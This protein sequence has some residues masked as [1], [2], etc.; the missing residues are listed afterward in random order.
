MRKRKCLLCEKRVSG[1]EA[2]NNGRR[3]SSA[4]PTKSSGHRESREG[5][6]DSTLSTPRLHINFLAPTRTLHFGPP[7]KVD[8]PHCISWERTQKR[9][10]HKL[11][12]ISGGFWGSKRVCQMGLS[13]PQKVEFIVFLPLKHIASGVMTSGYLQHLTYCN[14]T[15]K[16]KSWDWGEVLVHQIKKLPHQSWS[17]IFAD[18]TLEQK[19]TDGFKPNTPMS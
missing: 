5:P 9:D 16:G 7:E 1:I 13:G 18:A 19:L 6:N 12:E 3:P 8:V 17:S 14:R 2:S 10:P 11:F 15:W 4:G